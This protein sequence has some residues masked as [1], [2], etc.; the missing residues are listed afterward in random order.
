VRRLALSVCVTT[1]IALEPFTGAAAVAP[2]RRLAIYYGYPS[3]VEGAAGDVARAIR[4]FAM[5]DDIVFGDGL[6]LGRESPDAGL[7]AEHARL[8]QLVPGLRATAGTPALW[9]YV[10]LGRSQQLTQDAIVRRID[11]WKA[12]GVDGIFFDEAGRDFGVTPERRTAAVRASHERNLSVF[13]NAFDPND[14]FEG[15]SARRLPDPGALGARDALLIESFAVREGVRQTGEATAKRA[16]DALAWRARTGVKVLATTTAVGP[17]DAE[18]FAFAW[19]QAAALGLDG[20]GW[21]EPHFS[22]D[23]RLPWRDRPAEERTG[24]KP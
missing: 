9:G 17:F 2:P 12:L 11:A 1:A 20:I 7:R 22:A 21:G 15:W 13:M 24:K 8:T 18:A 5:Y 6:E 4:I 10:D 3:L 19:R 14:L 23:S 16:T